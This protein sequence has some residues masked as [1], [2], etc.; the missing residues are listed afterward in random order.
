[1]VESMMDKI[2]L[3]IANINYI[4]DFNTKE[5]IKESIKEQIRNI[6]QKK[7]VESN[8]SLTIK[9]IHYFISFSQKRITLISN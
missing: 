5:N 3:N 4:Q 1:M 7:L 9:I 8:N 6:Y 2:Q